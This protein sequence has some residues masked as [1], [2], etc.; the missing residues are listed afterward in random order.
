MR[1]ITIE[2]YESMDVPAKTDKVLID[3]MRSF[4]EVG[5]VSS[6]MMFKNGKVDHR[7]QVYP[8]GHKE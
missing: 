7:I 8:K 1:T 2:F 5:F 6:S 4:K 3:A